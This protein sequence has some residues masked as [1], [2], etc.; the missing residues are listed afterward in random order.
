MIGQIKYRVAGLGTCSYIDR[1]VYMEIFKQ[2]FWWYDN[3]ISST[4]ITL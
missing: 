1:D 3:R 4:L 2:I